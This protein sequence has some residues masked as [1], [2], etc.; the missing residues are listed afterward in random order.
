M[1]E[2]FTDA[3]FAEKVEKSDKLVVVDL[4]RMVRPMPDGRPDHT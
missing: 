4:R 1:F 2:T 3:N